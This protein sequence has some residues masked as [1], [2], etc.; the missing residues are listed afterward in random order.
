LGSFIR[1]VYLLKSAPTS[2]ST[3]TSAGIPGVHG[4]MQD[5]DRGPKIRGED[6]GSLTPR[7]R[8]VKRIFETMQDL[9]QLPPHTSLVFG[10][11]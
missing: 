9:A 3:V 7:I 11:R 10:H 8:I 6:V 1:T 2:G 5:G 4:A